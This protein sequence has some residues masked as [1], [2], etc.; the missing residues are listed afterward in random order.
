MVGPGGGYISFRCRISRAQIPSLLAQGYHIS[1]AERIRRDAADYQ[2]LLVPPLGQALPQDRRD[3]E[4]EDHLRLAERVGR[5][6]PGF[7]FWDNN[8]P[9]AERRRLYRGGTILPALGNNAHLEEAREIAQGS[10]TAGIETLTVSKGRPSK[11]TAPTAAVGTAISYMAP[12]TGAAQAVVIA[13][14]KNRYFID[15]LLCSAEGRVS[16]WRL[17]WFRHRVGRINPRPGQM[18]ELV[19]AIPGCL[20]LAAI[21]SSCGGMLNYSPGD[22]VDR[23]GEAPS[24]CWQEGADSE[25]GI[26]WV[27]VTVRFG[28]LSAVPPLGAIPKLNCPPPG[29]STGH[30]VWWGV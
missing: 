14:A 9:I 19:V 20:V 25:T 12:E 1:L 28:S 24:G 5:D 10:M 13:I 17:W 29:G 6:W 3:V 27:G 16:A 22:I 11:I 30:A 2:R 8:T 15:C 21:S 23:E 18:T 4:F 26:A 7:A